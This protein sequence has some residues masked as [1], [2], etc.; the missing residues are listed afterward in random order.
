MSPLSL[1]AERIRYTGARPPPRPS[2]TLPANTP[3]RDGLCAVL[4]RLRPLA[5]VL[6]LTPHPHP[7]P[8][9]S[10]VTC[11]RHPPRRHTEA[12]R[13]RRRT[14]MIC[15]H[16]RWMIS[17]VTSFWFQQAT[18]LARPIDLLH[19]SRID[20]RRWRPCVQKRNNDNCPRPRGRHACACQRAL[21]VFIGDGAQNKREEPFN[22]HYVTV[23]AAAVRTSKKI[24]AG[25][26]SNNAK[27]K[28]TSERKRPAR[29]GIAESEPRAEK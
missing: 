26:N 7:T 11:D 9:A 23:R 19:D 29:P 5:L 16:L 8:P 25:V 1:S 13:T 2:H 4:A 28:Q 20:G 21:N 6:A 3:G 22:G 15:G 27:C 14:T 18:A 12:C 17:M 24:F 10:A